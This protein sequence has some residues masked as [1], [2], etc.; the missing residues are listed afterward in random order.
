M[1]A[2]TITS[3]CLL[4]AIIITLWHAST[5]KPPLWVPVFLLEIVML[6]QLLPVR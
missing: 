6:L 3:L 5:G 2:L 4:S 1:M